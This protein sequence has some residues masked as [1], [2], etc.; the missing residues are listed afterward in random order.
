MPVK[1]R[2]QQKLFQAASHGADFAMARKV[3]ASMSAQ[4]MHDFAVGSE[5]S[6]PQHVK[7]AKPLHPVLQQRALMVKQA[8]QHLSTAIPGFTRLPAR[9]RMLA[10]QHHVNLRLGKV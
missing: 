1:S 8:H 7:P 6:K 5:A 10:V 3:R 4:Q 2:A 9:Q